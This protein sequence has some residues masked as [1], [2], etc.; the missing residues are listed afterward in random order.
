MKLH[1]GCGKHIMEGWI[2]LD[3]MALPGVDIVADLDAKS[4]EGRVSIP[5]GDNSVEEFYCAHVLE[6]IRY[7]LAMMEELHRIAKPGAVI[8]F[9][10]PY[11]SS[12]GAWEDPTHVRPLFP[13]SF[14]YFGQPYYHLA[15]YGYRGDW[16]ITQIQ[17]H[18][19]NGPLAS[20]PD[21]EVIRQT[22]RR[23]RNVVGGMIAYLTAIKPIR[24]QDVNLGYKPEIR[25]LFAIPQ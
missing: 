22:I 23:D 10:V 6:H 13:E 15:D 20:E 2:N 16:Q 24:E 3:H 14:G 12:D 11:G 25:Y 21:I 9:S 17:L 19:P 7:P 4:P 18:L 5:L 8:Q 1:L